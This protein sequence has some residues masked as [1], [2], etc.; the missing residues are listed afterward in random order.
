MGLRES[1]AAALK[2]RNNRPQ[3]APPPTIPPPASPTSAD[4]TGQPAA[5]PVASFDARPSGGL[6][7]KMAHMR[8]LQQASQAPALSQ[9]PPD[10]PQPTQQC[11][12]REINGRWVAFGSS[13]S[14]P[15]SPINGAGL[16]GRPLLHAA[17]PQQQQQ[18]QH[19]GINRS[20]ARAKVELPA[21]ADD[22]LHDASA[23]LRRAGAAS[24]SSAGT[25]ASGR[26]QREAGEQRGACS[27][28]QQQQQQQQQQQPQLQLASDLDDFLPGSSQRPSPQKA[29]RKRGGSATT[30][31]SMA[32]RKA[33]GAAAKAKAAASGKGG[34]GKGGGR[35]A[36][37][38][39][40]KRDR[41]VIDEDDE[42]EEAAEG[43]EDEA[44]E[45]EEEGLLDKLLVPL[46][47]AQ[48]QQQ[49]QAEPAAPANAPLGGPNEELRLVVDEK[50]EP[51]PDD[52]AEEPYLELAVPATINR[53]LRS[54]QRDGIRFLMRNYARG[55]GAVL[56]DDMGLGKTVQAIGFI[57]AVL[58]K[59]GDPDDA[60]E[61]RLAP[62]ETAEPLAAWHKNVRVEDLSEERFEPNYARCYP[63]LVVVP[64]SVMDNWEREFNM[65][66]KFRV[67]KCDSKHKS[68][69]LAS[70]KA[71]KK[72][73]ML[74]GYPIFSAKGDLVQALLEIPWHMVIFDEAHNLK[75][76][77]TKRYQTV[78]QL[79]TRLRY[80]LTGT[81]FQND[82][83]ELFDL[84][85][86]L[87]P[88][89]LGSAGE[90]LT[91]FSKPIM[92]GQKS[93]STDFQK[94]VGAEAQQDLRRR[95]SGYLLRRT[96]RLIADQLPRKMD[97]AV[98]CEL[99]PL[100]L[101][102]Y[103]RLLQSPDVELLLNAYK[104]PCLLCDS[105]SPYWM[106]CGW[107]VDED[108]GGVL[109]PLYH[110]CE[111]DNPHDPVLNPNGCK[112][113]KPDGHYFPGGRMR[114]CPFCLILP[115]VKALHEDE[116]K[117]PLK[118]SRALQIAELVIG[119][120]DE[121]L[122]GYVTTED[123][124]RLSDT[125]TCGKMQALSALLDD[126]YSK[127]GNKVLLFSNSVQMLNILRKMVISK[128]YGHEMLDG[129]TKA[130]DRQVMCDRFNTQPSLFIFLI[131]TMAGGT[132]LNLTAANKVVIFDPS[133][134][135]AQD[136]QAQDRAFRIGQKRDVSVYRL[137]A[138]GTLEECIYDRQIYKTIHAE[139]VEGNDAMA[140][141][142]QGA[143]TGKREDHGELFG[144]LNML[145]FNTEHI[146]TLDLL[147]AERR[148][149]AQL[150]APRVVD[151]DIEAVAAAAPAA[152]AA[153][154]QGQA[155]R[156]G[157][158]VL[159]YVSDGDDPG[160]QALVEG[161]LGLIH[162]EGEEGQPAP[163]TAAAAAAA[164]AGG[165]ARGAPRSSVAAATQPAGG[166]GGGEEEEEEGERGGNGGV[167]DNE[168]YRLLAAEHAQEERWAEHRDETVLLATHRLPFKRSEAEV[169]ITQ[170]AK[171]A[172]E[173]SNQTKG[174]QFAKTAIALADRP[175]TSR[176]VRAK[177]DKVLAAAGLGQQD[178]QQGLLQSEPLPLLPSL[179]QAMG[180]PLEVTAKQLLEM[181]PSGRRQLREDL[182]QT[183]D[184]GLV[185]RQG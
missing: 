179:A 141:T 9:A 167:V 124:V 117:D 157:S 122:G 175:K 94:A 63:I 133:W 21:D 160:L 26:Q 95:L 72:E 49:Q 184:H 23:A 164:A 168:R 76:H 34:G 177:P 79:P 113:H 146:L 178:I 165:A 24:G 91:G 67:A 174:D 13:H 185:L 38:S 108:Q 86:I 27:G 50:G 82:Y 14:A 153:Q 98:F 120:D 59:L 101:A 118:F 99:A 134:N 158:A 151:L 121:A 41:Q 88:G 3:Q 172:V 106:C 135:P 130:E 19:D 48:Q 116:K 17:S 28:S 173:R 107:R 36:A 156:D 149:R 11:G 12:R 64:V 18:Q 35:R 115:L 152:A 123:F 47:P 85:D 89:C 55:M 142:F 97:F 127:G 29:G 5:S 114:S 75:N 169:Q 171:A 159:E 155:A 105:R 126:W 62:L 69:A 74:A 56:A 4:A 112:S 139:I 90:F 71:G 81:P 8:R 65:W 161:E 32:K 162:G 6:A 31:A 61:P 119:E 147:E 78:D 125:S 30:P 143:K 60:Y 2:Q 87:A 40:R 45:E 73:V 16:P 102:A 163:P 180:L 25:G 37:A 66:G 131:S 42:E 57:A 104:K 170:A 20:A 138:A 44:A 148:R 110:L 181:S 15:T 77:K 128:G 83:T 39:S 53:F 10:L 150:V 7:A 166:A 92:L 103:K 51:L 176:A 43:K 111:C 84:M 33:A 1:V 183:D 52:S 68:T 70:I 182:A 144:M 54:Y 22:F 93:D 145:R 96:K 154:S 137:I 109:W 136:A 46:S 140:R 58:G 129:S 80:G 100:Q 132:G